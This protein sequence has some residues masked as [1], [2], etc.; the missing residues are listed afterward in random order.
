VCA[1]ACVCVCVKVRACMRERKF[2]RE[3]V[4][5]RAFVCAYMYVRSCAW[6]D[7]CVCVCVCV[8]VYECWYEC[9]LFLTSVS[10]LSV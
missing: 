4:D 1:H 10:L 7:V 2:V 8:C 3:R 5:S 9:V 6:L